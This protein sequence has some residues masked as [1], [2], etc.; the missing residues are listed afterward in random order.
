MMTIPVVEVD[1]LGPDG[2]RAFALAFYGV[3]D[4]APIRI[5]KVL[6]RRGLFGYQA[7]AYIRRRSYVQAAPR[8]AAPPVEDQP[9]A[10]PLRRWR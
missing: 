1:I 10:L 7:A 5:Q 2:N 6:H 9:F 3:E 4:V 8:P